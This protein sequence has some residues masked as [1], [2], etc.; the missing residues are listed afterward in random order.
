MYNTFWKIISSTEIIIPI[1]QRDYAY[2][3]VEALNILANLLN[4]IKDVIEQK[5]DQTKQL[6]LAF[7]YGKLEGKQND[8]L[9]LR[10]SENIK[11]LL[12]SVKEYA[13]DLDI[14]VDFNTARDIVRL[15]D[16]VKFIPIDGQQRLTTLFLLHWYLAIHCRQYNDLI[17]LKKFQYATRVSSKNFC[18]LICSIADV[19]EDTE[20]NSEFVTNQE[21]YFKQWYNDPTVQN[22]LTVIDRI[23]D[24]FKSDKSKFS[25]YYQKLK[26][27]DTV[28]FDF[29]DLDNFQQTDDLYVKMNS[30]GKKLTQFENFKAWLYH[31]K[32]I[33]TGMKKK[34]D[35]DWYDLFW[36]AQKKNP[37][38][39]DT[40]YLQWFK[41]L[42]LA[43][44][45][46]EKEKD[47]KNVN[48]L[49]DSTELEQYQNT[50]PSDTE[51]TKSI[52]AFLRK[53]DSK[54]L[55][56]LIGN[57]NFR[58]QFLSNINFYFDTL[59]TISENY[60]N[61]LRVEINANY[62]EGNIEQLLF[63]EQ[64]NLNWW[65]VTLQY[66]IIKYL[67]KYNYDEKELKN[68][69]R[70]IS[71]LIFNSTIDS[72]RDYVKAIKSIDS[73]IEECNQNILRYLKNIE[74]DRISFFST[75]QKEEEKEKAYLCSDE[76]NGDNWLNAIINAELHPYFY[77]QI[78]FVFG[79][80]NHINLDE[81]NL[82]FRRIANVFS[83]EILNQSNNFLFR[84]LVS[85]IGKELFIKDGQILRYPINDGARLRSRNE[86]WRR[87]LLNNDKIKLLS[88]LME[89]SEL[90]SEETT[91]KYL[92]KLI[93][94]YT[95]TN[96][97][98]YPIIKNEELLKNARRE[99]LCDYNEDENLIYLLNTTS[100]RGYYR[101]LLTVDW[102][103]KNVT[104]YSDDNS[105]TIALLDL[106]YDIDEI[107]GLNIVNKVTDK[108]YW[109]SKSDSGFI[110]ELYTIVDNQKGELIK[111]DN[112]IESLIN[113]IKELK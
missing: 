113:Y 39:I 56:F 16:N 65:Q 42:A 64:N 49:N 106:Q 22:M 76:L 96:N 81:F 6:H 35:I 46:K 9:L 60:K 109:L 8:Q 88:D 63:T 17:I 62:F 69:L 45:L 102:Y 7:V 58:I 78:G 41:N 10:N 82:N 79:L 54:F 1:I 105:V 104:I 33:D 72:P 44:F 32:D 3:R 50:N 37:N 99:C 112:N 98:L 34:I 57:E 25:N 18:E 70:V 107:P 30:R 90:D 43:D 92:K 111:T 38:E 59:S 73:I 31:Q 14:F 40:V 53:S 19:K 48:E 68:Y 13:S 103:L 47:E 84:S 27:T 52:I 61:K 100:L 67:N 95:D 71:N 110:F 85:K 101:E 89:Q 77:G 4:N 15:A 11:A 29:F 5:N 55:D 80:C 12:Q 51:I 66:A 2:G 108:R 91:K 20:I 21:G 74:I 75:I 83:N 86:N 97:F 23:N 28:C 36:Q 24:L 93:E 87:C 94:N 26:N